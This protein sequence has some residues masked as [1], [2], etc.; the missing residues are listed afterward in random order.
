MTTWLLT[1]IITFVFIAL[2]LLG[3]GIGRLLTGKTKISKGCGNP[4]IKSDQ[5]C[6]GQRN[7]SLC[8][9]KKEN[10]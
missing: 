3:L 1:V 10:S 5:D 4:S 9:E 6:K 7:C 8:Q 2:A